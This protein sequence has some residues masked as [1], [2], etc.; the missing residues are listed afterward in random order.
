MSEQK[1]DSPLVG[2]VDEPTLDDKGLKRLTFSLK[3]H[4]MKDI[5]DQYITP[6][7]EK[8][9]GGN[10]KFT[11]FRSKSGKLC[12][13]IFN[14]NGEWAKKKREEKTQET[15]EVDDSGLPF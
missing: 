12:M 14:P 10:A 11:I 6:R 9:H 7:N 5:L 13:D 1:H 2:W 4:E 3:D 15:A 8:G